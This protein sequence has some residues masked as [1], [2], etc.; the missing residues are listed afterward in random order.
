MIKQK[1]RG[2]VFLGGIWFFSFNLVYASTTCTYTDEFAGAKCFQVWDEVTREPKI[3]DGLKIGGHCVG[4]V[5]SWDMVEECTNPT[6]NVQP[7]GTVDNIAPSCTVKALSSGVVVGGVTWFK[8]KVKIGVATCSD[9]LSGCRWDTRTNNFVLS[10][11][12]TASVTIKDFAGNS[13]TCSSASLNIDKL[14]PNFYDSTKVLMK[15]PED[16]TSR[17][18]NYRPLSTVAVENFRADSIYEFKL[19]VRDETGSSSGASGLDIEKTRI[20]L[21]SKADVE[22]DINIQVSDVGSISAELLPGNKGIYIKLQNAGILEKVGEYYLQFIVVDKVGNRIS[23]GDLIKIRILPGNVDETKSEILINKGGDCGLADGVDNCV[24]NFN[25][26]DQF[27]NFIYKVADVF[28]YTIPSPSCTINFNGS[29]YKYPTENTM[30][31]D[32]NCSNVLFTKMSCRWFD[33][34]NNLISKG[35]NSDGFD[36]SLIYE[37]L[38]RNILNFSSGS[39][40]F[41]K[42]PYW[43]EKTK[44]KCR[45]KAYGFD[46]SSSL[47]PVQSVNIDPDSNYCTTFLDGER[48]PY[49]D[50]CIVK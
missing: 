8:D 21:K 35:V 24:L 20:I 26:R 22:S 49:A 3:G 4:D 46:G 23:T 2:L 6:E 29:S 50:T 10:H 18:D 27:S 45:I 31:F 13:T 33:L 5:V 15:V 36:N 25:L 32:W 48:E 38:T 42:V 30:Q 37:H 9:N 41:G 17:S 47:L 40:N 16:V 39:L 11:G 44:L 12:G 28:N 7:A 14:A 19:L 43:Y 1:N 34:T